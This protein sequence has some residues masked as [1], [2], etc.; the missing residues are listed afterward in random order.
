VG[1]RITETT[2]SAAQAYLKRIATDICRELT[3]A[4]GTSLAVVERDIEKNRLLA[5]VGL[6]WAKN[7][8]RIQKALKVL[9]IDE[10]TW[11][12][13]ELGLALNTLRG[14][15]QVARSWK[16]YERKGASWATLG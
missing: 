6:M 8:E 4:D 13:R 12:K 16:A 1:S 14:Y 9:N 2:R 11:C 10:N 7:R 5:N 3:K 15:R